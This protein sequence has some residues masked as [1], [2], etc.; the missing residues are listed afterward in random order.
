MHEGFIRGVLRDRQRGHYNPHKI[1]VQKCPSGRQAGEQ[2]VRQKYA[3]EVK[4]YRRRASCTETW[5]IVVIDADT[6]SVRNRMDEL[7]AELDEHGLEARTNDEKIVIVVPR[8]NMET[9]FR[10]LQGHPVNETDDYSM[11]RPILP[12]RQYGSAFSG[13]CRTT[14][15]PDAPD[16]LR[17]ACP[18]VARVI[19]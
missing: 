11:K 13:K 10:Y 14:L 15:P 5:L 4:A 1:R 17:R 18:E 16:S 6:G 19:P 8:R 12:P 3:A 9:C 2:Y 7:N